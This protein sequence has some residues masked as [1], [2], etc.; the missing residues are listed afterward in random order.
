MS[1]TTASD[2]PDTSAAS[3]LGPDAREGSREW[4]SDEAP[5][6]QQASP[7]TMVGDAGSAVCVDGV[8]IVPGTIPDEA[9][10]SPGAR[11][12]VL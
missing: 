12:T 9:E 6:Q 11:H 10:G 4:D 2:R 5:S 1:D 8:C 7:F 3:D